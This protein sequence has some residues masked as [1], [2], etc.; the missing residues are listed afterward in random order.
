M[1]V[2][3]TRTEPG[4]NRLGTALAAA[5]Y[6]ARVRPVLRIDPITGP[7]PAGRFALTVF[8]SVHAA[9]FA[10]RNGWISTPALA[11]GEATRG[12]LKRHGVDASVPKIG[13]SEGL[14][15]NLAADPPQSVMIAAG[16]GGRGVL[17]RWL[18]DRGIPTVKWR[19]YRRVA[20]GGS[21]DPAETIDA[22]V[23]SSAAALRVVANMWFASSRSA[24]VAL[25]VPSKRVATAAS[26]L[27]FARV[28]VSEGA[29][30]EAVI[31]TLNRIAN[32]HPD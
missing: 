18:A 12:A 32:E 30:D 8:L 22:I 29:A 21:L 14:I 26:A 5:G 7:P 17:E 23:G 6:E 25:L 10:V 19:L 11:I 4:A 9:E 2:W 31:A 1:R 13:T 3:V 28:F 24:R 16:E 27:G 20:V 15:D